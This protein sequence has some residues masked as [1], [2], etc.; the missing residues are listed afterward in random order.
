M[1]KIILILDGMADRAQKALSDKTPLEYAHTPNLD[2]LFAKAEVGCIQTIP[3]GEEAGSAVAN[4]NLLGFTSA[5]VYKGR[6][7]IE[8]AGAEMKMDKD[9]LYIRTN[10]ITLEG[11]SFGDSAI[12]NY[13]AHDIKTSDAKKL[14]QRLN[15]EIFKGDMKLH[16]SGSFRNILVVKNK[17]DQYGKL[18][19]I[20]PHDMLMQPIKN[21]IKEDTVSAPY[22][23]LLE[24]AYDVLSK[25]NDTKANGIWFWGAS[26]VPEIKNTTDDKKVILSETILM[27][28][29]ANL[30]GIDCISVKEYKGFEVF[31]QD[32]LVASLNAIKDD[33][34]LIYIHIQK[35]DDLSH[36]LQPRQ[37]AEALETI[38]K[39]FVGQLAAS[40]EGAYSLVIA[41]DHYTYSDTGAH[42]REPAPFMMITNNNIAHQRKE[43][44]T[45][46]NCVNEDNVIT[47][48]HLHNMF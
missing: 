22:Y 44:F 28:G 46:N 42:G 1:K 16:H 29:I 9:S 13:S 3:Y 23:K 38:D 33:Y 37:K 10:F 30:A 41:S 7:A 27:R 36:E 47:T 17:T 40:L 5:D 11:R 2:D 25:D 4:L 20:P 48:Q 8:A 21:C 43:Q 18:H 32:K 15:N 35:P 31:L 34:D 14:T 12:V 19:F 24:N 6:A 39:V 45:E 26:V